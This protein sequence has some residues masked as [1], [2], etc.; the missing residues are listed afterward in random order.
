[1]LVFE[2]DEVQE[3][4]HKAKMLN[5]RE[6]KVFYKNEAN[7]N[8]LSV[9]P[10]L[11]PEAPIYAEESQHSTRNCYKATFGE[12]PKIKCMIVVI[13]PFCVPDNICHFAAQE[14]AMTVD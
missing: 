11:D 9:K 3:T 4:E 10:Q 8:T 6:P 12:V 14:A 2:L 1:M 5:H 7:I 13:L